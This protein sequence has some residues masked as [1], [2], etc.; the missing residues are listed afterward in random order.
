MLESLR[1]QK[2]VE[3]E[4]VVLDNTNGES[5]DVGFVQK[6]FP[7]VK[8]FQKE[9]TGFSKGHNFLISQAKYPLYA[10]LNPDM[11]FDEYF[12]DHLSEAFSLQNVASASGKLLRWDFN[13]QEKT[14]IIDSCGLLKT[15][16][17]RFFDMGQSEQDSG[18]Y[19]QEVF[20]FGPSG[21]AALYR[22][23]ALEKIKQNGEIFDESFFMYKEDCDL[24]AKLHY[25]GYDS[26]F[27]SS[28]QAWHDRT[29]SSDEVGSFLVRQKKKGFLV[30]VWS[31][32][33]Q[34]YLVKNHWKHLS[35]F[36]KIN[37]ASSLFAEHIY[38]LLF[39][40]AVF[41]EVMKRGRN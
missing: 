17:F 34:K 18:Q 2:D 16:S 31:F 36:E 3:I 28:A 33:H 32:L 26:A 39:D 10:C 15:S 25:A 30:K 40:R 38:Y 21:A 37:T 7:E 12:L 23:S 20:I 29:V 13:N 5:D 9:N 19:D 1:S 22:I 35:L 8:I 4:I 27:V 41:F 11:I 24:A 6:E 14:D